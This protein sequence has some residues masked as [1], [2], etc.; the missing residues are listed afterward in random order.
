MTEENLSKAYK[1]GR[2][3]ETI[4][5]TMNSSYLPKNF[6]ETDIYIGSVVF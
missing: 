6:L 3:H 4:L 5:T 2:T 1:K